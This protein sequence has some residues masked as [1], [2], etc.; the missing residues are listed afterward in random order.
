MSRSRTPQAPHAARSAMFSSRISC[1]RKSRTLTGHL[2]R[3]GPGRARL[4]FRAVSESGCR[5]CCCNKVTPKHSNSDR[6]W[7]PSH[8][9]V[10]MGPTRP[11]DRA[12]DAGTFHPCLA[13]PSGQFPPPSHYPQAY[14]LHHGEGKGQSTLVWKL[15]RALRL[16]SDRSECDH[17]VTPTAREAG[18][19]SL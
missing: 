19:C 5:R 4:R 15:H 11:P 18:K 17:M 13:I 8:A 3:E 12:E 10:R 16:T 6:G 14:S 9:D 7:F 2:S 1:P